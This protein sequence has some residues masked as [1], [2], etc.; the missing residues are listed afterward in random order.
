MN[1]TR[2]VTLDDVPALTRIVRAN[3][4]FLAPWDP[5][6]PESYFTTHGQEQVIGSV[7][8]EHAQGRSLPHVILDGSGDVVGRITLSGIVRG[9]FQSGALGYWVSEAAN[10]RG[11]ATAAVLDLERVVFDE[12]GLHRIQAETLRH[13]AASQRVLERTGFTTFGVA[14]TYLKIAGEWQDCVMYQAI[15][16]HP[17]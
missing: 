10:G 5:L 11:L 3:R 4:E 14:P 2:L 13:N 9:P 17:D 16:P 6:R 8:A 15:T 7:L 1:A 12:M